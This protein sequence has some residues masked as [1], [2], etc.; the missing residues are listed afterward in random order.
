MK[1][2]NIILLFFCMLLVFI[3][4]GC[5]KG[6]SVTNDNSKISE[7]LSNA[8]SNSKVEATTKEDNVKKASLNKISDDNELQPSNTILDLQNSLREIAEKRIPAVVNI[9]SEMEVTDSTY[10]NFYDFYDFWKKFRG[11]NDGED[12]KK[13]EKNKRTQEALGSGFIIS[14]D[15]YVVTNNHV[16]DNA[17]KITVT[18]SDERTFDAKLI[19]HDPKTDTALLK[20]ESDEELPT[21]PLGDSSTIR[22]GDIAVAIGNPF[23]LSGSFTMG[24]ISATG[25]DSG[26]DIDASFKSYI[27]TDAP[28]NQGNS[29]G[30]LLNLYG[31]VIGMNT[32]IYSTTG[33]SIGI[34]FAIPINIVKNIVEDLADDGQVER[35]MLGLTVTNLDEDLAKKYGIKPNE[36]AVVNDV[37]DDSPAKEA[38]IKSLDVIIKIDDM[39]IKSSEQVVQKVVSYKVG[40]VISVTLLRLKNQTQVETITVQV[41]L[42]L[43]EESR[44]EAL[45]SSDSKIPHSGKGNT[46]E[47]MGMTLGNLTDYK[48]E[49]KLPEN[50]KNGLVVLKVDED[51]VASKKGIMEGVIITSINNEVVE[52]VNDLKKIKETDSYLLKIYIEGQSS[53]VIIK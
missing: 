3:F 32:A 52:N 4:I 53:F 34:G 25:R 39:K 7:S 49:M 24:V 21:V 2:T 22:V 46:K 43:R 27:Q 37:I 38:G 26:I 17:V 48:E 20:I 18:L 42:G 8:L 13:P 31:E 40:D 12:G 35:P 23:G 5:D 45:K 51:S 29:G 33:G 50:I 19:G 36:G 15:G 1:R 30:P 11:D 16:I 28:I 6:T 41:K 14:N 44:F 9:R 10:S 47:W